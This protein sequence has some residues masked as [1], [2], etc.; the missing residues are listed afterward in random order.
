MALEPGDRV[1]MG[2][3]KAY[4][5]GTVIE[6]Q[7]RN[8]EGK[9]FVVWDRFPDRFTAYSSGEVRKVRKGEEEKFKEMN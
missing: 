2:Y 4:H 6:G 9:V 1:T 7:F 3:D 5:Y 8:N